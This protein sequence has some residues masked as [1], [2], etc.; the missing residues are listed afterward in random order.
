ML[1]LLFAISS[2]LPGK[3][4]SLMQT[5]YLM[6]QTLALGA[7]CGAVTVSWPFTGAGW[8]CQVQLQT[9]SLDMFQSKVAHLTYAQNWNYA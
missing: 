9:L 4:P 1:S 7:A 2:K 5:V 3:V 6:N 8:F